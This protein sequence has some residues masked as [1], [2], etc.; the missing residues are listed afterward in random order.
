MEY[1]ALEIDRKFWCPET[2]RGG[3]YGNGIQLHDLRNPGYFNY[4]IIEG[5]SYE[6]KV[7]KV[8][9]NET[10][11]IIEITKEPNLE[12]YKNTIHKEWKNWD[13][14]YGH[15]DEENRSDYQPWALISKDAL[16]ANLGL[17]QYNSDVSGN[18]YWWKKDQNKIEIINNLSGGSTGKNNINTML[19]K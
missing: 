19:Q 14:K 5:V 18:M 4:K 1:I 3:G 16:A 13:L 9:N 7:L 8:K 2:G 10:G 15:L 12:L 6:N 17:I 11:E